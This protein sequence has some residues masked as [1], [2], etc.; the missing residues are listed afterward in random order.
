M[1]FRQ[2]SQGSNNRTDSQSSV[3]T[4]SEGD[5]NLKSFV[6]KGR[7]SKSWTLLTVLKV[8]VLAGAVLLLVAT[9]LAVVR[10]GGGN[11]N[12][13]VDTSKY[14]AVFLNNGQVYF[15]KAKDVNTRF[16]KLADVYYLTQ[17]TGT[18]G[19][20]SGDYTLVKLGCQQIHNPQDQMV[21][22]REQVTFW[23]N[24]E[25]SGKVTKSIADFKKQYPNGPNC[26]EQTSQTPA[27]GTPS[28]S[29]NGAGSTTQTNS[30]TGT[31][32][33]KTTTPNTN[34]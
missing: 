27:T 13:L 3:T 34:N 17:S 25:S 12:G 10:G 15:G 11:E 2:A 26:D 8:L 31:T 6:K 32:A 29:S 5:S 4:G 24:L 14:Q 22:T 7:G 9:T 33:P 30:G 16:V 28:Q 21:I 23:E 18:N 1:D 20:A 19:Q